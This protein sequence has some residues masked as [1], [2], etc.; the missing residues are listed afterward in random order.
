[1]NKKIVAI[2]ES[3]HDRVQSLLPW[4]VN[5]TLREE[6]ASLVNQH[7]NVCSECQADFAWQCK[8]RAIEPAVEGAPDVDRAFAKLRERIDAKQ[9]QS[10][11]T[12]VWF[13]QFRFK[14]SPWMPWALASQMLLIMGLVTVV[15]TPDPTIATYRALAAN[16]TSNGN[17]IVVF[18][19]ETSEQQLRRILNRANARIVNGPTV[20]DAYVLYVKD[21]N[22]DATL[23]SLRADR[24]VVLAETLNSRGKLSE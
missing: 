19:P 12:S 7:L 8:L 21:E 3:M 9:I 6:D 18:R 17:M 4:F 2:N 5:D 1:M 20:T 15:A 23:R 22:L 13:N 16:S 24:A 10:K 11:R 14:N